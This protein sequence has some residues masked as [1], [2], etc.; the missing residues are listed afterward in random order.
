LAKQI[1]S[2]GLSD[3]VRL[4]GPQPQREVIRYLRNAA[5]LAAPCVLGHDGN[6]DGLPTVLLEAMALGTPCVSTDVTG[7]PEVLHHEKTGLL[8]PQNDPTALAQ[9][10]ERLLCDQPFRIRLANRARQ[11]IDKDFDIHLNAAQLRKLLFAPRAAVEARE[12]KVCV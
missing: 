9:R 12:R 1:V 4:I 8:V 10:L 7:I 3:R 11:L 6:R 2:L 5:A